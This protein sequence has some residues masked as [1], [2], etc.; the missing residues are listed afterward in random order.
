LNGADPLTNYAYKAEMDSLQTKYKAGIQDVAAG[1]S[2]ATTASDAEKQGANDYTN[3]S[4]VA[5]NGKIITIPTSGNKAGEAAAGSFKKGYQDAVDGKDDSTFTD[6]VQKATQEVASQTF[7]G[8]TNSTIKTP[9]EIKTMNPVAQVAYQKAEQEAEADTA[10]AGYTDGQSGKKLHQRTQATR[11]VIVPVPMA[12][13]RVLR[14]KVLFMFWF[15]TVAT[16]SC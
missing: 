1:T 7:K 5:V 10:K 12:V 13:Q 3:G 9:D 6:P 16:T 2:P 8:V 14:I 15:M 4:N 11:L